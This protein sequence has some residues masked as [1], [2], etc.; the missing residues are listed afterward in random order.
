MSKMRKINYNLT[1]GINP[2]QRVGHRKLEPVMY[3]P[4]EMNKYSPPVKTR[5]NSGHHPEFNQTLRHF[6]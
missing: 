6:S 5:I 4:M 1:P 2:N 3:R